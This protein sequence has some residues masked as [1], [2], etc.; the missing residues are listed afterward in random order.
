MG[1]SKEEVERAFRENLKKLNCVSCKE[2]ITDA[3]IDWGY[4]QPSDYARDG[5]FKVKCE[6]C[7]KVQSYDVFSRKLT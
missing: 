4:A 6:H 3:A 7:G 1:V 2:A 5:P